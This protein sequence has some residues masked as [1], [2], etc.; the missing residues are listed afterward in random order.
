MELNDDE[1]HYST[2]AAAETDNTAN[3][4]CS[5]GPTTPDENKEYST[6]GQAQPTN[7]ASG[8]NDY[9]YWLY[10]VVTDS[11]DPLKWLQLILINLLSKQVCK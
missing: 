7:T 6:Q 10:G 9:Q 4:Y 2:I 3:D 1:R 11:Q 5:I 8:Q